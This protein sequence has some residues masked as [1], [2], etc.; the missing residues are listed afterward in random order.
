[1]TDQIVAG[2]SRLFEEHRLVFWYD[3]GR[4]MREAY[5][6]LELPDVTKVEIQ[7]NEFGL[8]YRILKQEPE[9]RFLLF[10]DGPAPNDIDNWLLDLELA[11]VVFKADQSA[12]WLAELGLPTQLLGVVQ[13]HPE[14]Y[15]STKRIEALKQ[16]LN[17]SDQGTDIRRRM[18]AVSVGAEGGLDTV[19]ETLLGELAEDS[20]EGIRLLQR[21]NLLDFFWQQMAA[22]YGYSSTEPDLQDFAIALFEAAYKRDLGDDVVLSDEALLTFRRWK[23]ARQSAAA[24]ETLSARFYDVLNI[25][26]DLQ[27]R[28]FRDVMELDQYEKIDAYIITEIVRELSAETVGE[29]EVLRWIKTREQR[30]WFGRYEHVYRAI[31]AATELLQSLTSMTLSLSSLQEGVQ[32]YTAT[33]FKVDQQYRKFIFHLQKSG[34]AGLLADLF[35]R[36]ENRYTNNFLLRIN[37]A[38]QDQV[39]SMSK[40]EIGGYPKQTEFYR[41]HV[42]SYRQ[43]NQKVA[44]VISDA[45]RYEIAEECLRSIRKLNRFDADL[46]PM[47][48][49]LP[50][51][52][53]LGMAALLP[54]KALEFKPDGSGQILS[55]GE[56]TQGLD[57]RAK[58]LDKGRDGDRVRAFRSEEFAALTSDDAK[59]VFRDN[60]VVY[61]YHNRVDAV[62]DK[63]DTEEQLAEASEDAISDLVQLVRKLT[64]ANFTNI[65]ITAD[66]GF[67]YQHRKLD[68]ADFSIAEVT[69][70]T[71]TLRNRRFILGSGF[72]DEPGMKRFKSEDL[73]LA[74]DIDVLIPNSINR[75]RLKGAGSR[76]VHGG[77]SLQE[78][79]IPILRVGKQREA[80]VKQV[81]V[82][83]VFTGRSVISSGQLAVRLY[84][85]EAVTEK[86]QPRDLTVGIYSEDDVLLSDEHQFPF[87]LKSE[88]PRDR[89]I[90]VQF[91]MSKEA[92]RFNNQTVFLKLRERVGKTTKFQDYAVRSLSLRRGITD[93]DF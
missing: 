1:M 87:D 29:T 30:H 83:V 22:T 24:F 35:D 58:V 10:K 32:R 47:I 91:L 81:D 12:I 59:G 38:W 65:L 85:T 88:N 19:V 21:A 42:A 63:R 13:E 37:D 6:A 54:N 90:P 27:K 74:G 14:F 75:L 50:S 45:L 46:K 89:E 23:N 57:A 68:E 33:W 72:V 82:E 92:E 3:V 36:V 73:G 41:E 55:D 76:F 9:T 67:L 93:L 86:N 43:Q 39:S 79:I 84:Q 16:R 78:V 2:L 71:V 62:G 11:S 51:Y 52:T 69:S 44:V 66:H 49:A 4:D 48:S 34:S 40:W 53:Q 28:N 70:G 25:E 7:N 17:P 60:D 61:L 20:D 64:S 8:K 56:S 5:D 15:R 80:D 26:G 77:A 31:G 18:L